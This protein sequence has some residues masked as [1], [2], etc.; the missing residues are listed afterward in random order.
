LFNFSGNEMSARA[1]IVINDGQ[2]TPVS[3]TFNPNSGDGN[4]AGVSIIEYEDR[5]GGISVG[6]PRIS[7]QT[8]RSSKSSRNQKVTFK[9]ATPV[10]ETV[11]NST[12]SG[13][14]PAPTVAYANL[15]VG[16]FILPERSSLDSR[17]D[18]LAFVKNLFANAVVTSAITDLE[19]PW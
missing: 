13:I 12:V 11:S 8:R 19:S 2:A 17:K 3:H 10:L 16:E 7:V 9:V 1:N 5:S 14:A 18:L 15:F 6:F 4:V